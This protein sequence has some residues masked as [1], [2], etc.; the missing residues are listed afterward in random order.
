MENHKSIKNI[1]LII[2]DV[3]GILTNGRI[4]IDNNNNESKGFH[5]DDG[6]GVAL[7]RLA[8]I[9]IAFLSGRYS[10][11][12]TIRAREL[13]IKYCYQG[14]LDKITGF[15]DIITKYNLT[16]DKVC[17][18]GDGLIDLPPMDIA[19]FTVSV[20]NAHPIVKKQSDHITFRSGG[21]GVLLEVVEL[22]L[23]KQN[24]LNAIFSKM[25]K[26]KYGYKK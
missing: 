9:P 24:K 4:Y 26:E 6:A 2:S 14:Q 22:I 8:E 5:V 16:P 12:T 3:D 17:Y 7:A 20:P 25:T 19:G 13:Q 15:N 21:E 10:E 23:K 18:I 1:K 11:S